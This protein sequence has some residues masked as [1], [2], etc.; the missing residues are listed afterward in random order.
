MVWELFRRERALCSHKEYFVFWKKAES[1]NYRPD[2]VGPL[3]TSLDLHSNNI[4]QIPGRRQHWEKGAVLWEDGKQ[5]E[6]WCCL[7]PE[8]WSVTRGFR[9]AGEGGSSSPFT[10]T[11]CWQEVPQ[12]EGRIRCRNEERD[13]LL[14]LSPTWLG[15]G[16]WVCFLPHSKLSTLCQIICLPPLHSCFHFQGLCAWV[17]AWS[18]YSVCSWHW[19]A[20]VARWHTL[21]CSLRSP[22][23]YLSPSRQKR[24]K[25]AQDF[26]N[27]LK[28]MS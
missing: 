9:G 3:L 1:L 22:L 16:V 23:L 11:R 26:L 5:I 28:Q 27:F 14:S 10:V 4:K 2:V 13:S 6:K 19:S 15:K 24:P 17:T 8:E 18:P 25:S 7:D 21:S 12:K 20:P